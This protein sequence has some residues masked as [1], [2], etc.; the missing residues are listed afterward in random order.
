MADKEN[1]ELENTEVESTSAA[2]AEETKG[3]DKK[4]AK[5]AKPKKNKPSLASRIAAWFRSYKSEVKK[6]VW[7][8]PKNVWRNSVMTIVA[9]VATAI[10]VGLL[11]YIFN[12]GVDG[13]S[14]LF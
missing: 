2:P 12:S 14:R 10:V 9:I 6:I 5:A 3:K 11:D 1:M 13:L 7:T 4:S 8:S